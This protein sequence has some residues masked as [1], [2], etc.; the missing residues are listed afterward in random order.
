[1][2]RP[3][4]MEKW[5]DRKSIFQSE[6]YKI[7][8]ELGRGKSG[9]VHVL[10]DIKNGNQ[11]VLKET[12]N[13]SIFPKF[14]KIQTRVNQ[15]YDPS[16]QLHYEC[17]Q[18][19][20]DNY[21]NQVLI[22]MI[23]NQILQNQPNYL[24][25]HDFYLDQGSG[26]LV[27]EYANLGDLSD[28]IQ[29]ITLISERW[30]LDVFRQVCSPLV[31]LKQI[32]YGFLHSDLK[33]KNILVHRTPQ[34]EMIYKIA[35]FDK[36]S[37]YYEQ[38]RYFNDSYNYTIGYFKSSPFILHTDHPDYIYYTLADVDLYGRMIGF[39]EYVMSNPN[40]FFLSFDYYTF[41]YS[42]LLEKPILQWMLENQQSCV[43]NIYHY[44]FH[45]DEEQE[46][47]KFMDNLNDIY[48]GKIK[49]NRLSIVFYWQQ[50]KTC[51]FKLRY[52]VSKINQWLDIKILELFES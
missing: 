34:N 51:G 3:S 4:I 49:G 46:W 26:F 12:K 20:S 5:V 31:I 41:F 22:H 6:N 39:H 24:H 47:K 35:D 19:A 33:T 36:S 42:F 17:E 9:V 52:D 13:I 30:I 15:D 8:K 18:V 40:G 45:L 37:I 10:I 25:Q 32:K 48:S 16:F 38:V 23:L 50:F 21:T 29:K 7:Q 1:M 43:W 2:D 28:F 27:T 44:L 14:K 11:Y